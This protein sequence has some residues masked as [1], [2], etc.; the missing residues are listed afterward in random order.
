[1]CILYLF[2]ICNKLHLWNADF[3][4]DMSDLIEI[5]AKQDFQLFSMDVIT[6]DGTEKG[7]QMQCLHGWIIFECSAHVKPK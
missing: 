6:Y 7:A 1:M 2:K 4:M 5:L 3:H